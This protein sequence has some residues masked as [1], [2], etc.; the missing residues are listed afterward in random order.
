MKAK[1]QE[2]L[3]CKS[4]NEF[5]DFLTQTFKGCLY[6]CNSWAM[7]IMLFIVHSSIFI[8]KSSLENSTVSNQHPTSAL[9]PF[10]PWKSKTKS[11]YGITIIYLIY[12]KKIFQRRNNIVH[13]R[14]KTAKL[15]SI[16]H[17]RMQKQNIDQQDWKKKCST[18]R[19]Y[20]IPWIHEN[21]KKCFYMLTIMDHIGQFIY[22]QT[23]PLLPII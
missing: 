4:R 13:I 3:K 7:I 10:T 18:F 5:L 6:Q 22:I 17:L 19:V 11:N 14:H 20:Y 16:L 12:V 21:T 23:K 9:D 15:T 1:C 8:R 2:A